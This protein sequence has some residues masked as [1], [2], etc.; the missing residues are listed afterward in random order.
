MLAALV[1]AAA[2]P[3]EF[4]FVFPKGQLSLDA[5]IERV[6]E[7]LGSP[8]TGRLA[9]SSEYANWERAPGAVEMRLKA[10]LVTSIKLSRSDYNDAF[11]RL[12]DWSNPDQMKQWNADPN[13]LGFD[14]VF[15]IYDE[16]YKLV[17]Y[18]GEGIAFVEA[19]YLVGME[20]WMTLAIQHRID[21][22]RF[23]IEYDSTR[24]QKLAFLRGKPVFGIELMA[25]EEAGLRYPDENFAAKKSNR[26]LW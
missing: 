14:E 18:G 8:D 25:S 5:P 15:K 3:R 20:G 2:L 9:E 6:Y 12:P 7:V 24:E 10:G 22:D 1:M 23:E 17:Y 13:R 19:L 4:V 16:P 21:D 26:S 11:V